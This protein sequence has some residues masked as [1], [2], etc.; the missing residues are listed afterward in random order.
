MNLLSKIQSPRDL[1]TLTLSDL[2]HL[3]K[4]IRH[5]IIDVMAINGGHLG[6]NMGIVELSLALHRTFDAPID[7]LIFDV[8]HQTYPHKLLTGRQKEFPTIRQY[9]GL[10]G[11]ANPEESE[12]DTFFAGHAGTALSLGLGTAKARDLSH[13]NFHVI[14]II[15]DATFTCGLTLEA[16]NNLPHDLKRFIVILNDNNM[17]ISD[18]VGAITKILEGNCKTHF[19]Q[20]GFEYVGLID[21]HNL[22][23]L[24]DILESVKHCDQPILLHAKTLKGK[25]LEVAEQNPIPWHGCSPFDK[26]TGEKLAKTSTKS[27]F[28]QI[29]GKHIEKMAE[30]D[31]AIVIVTPAMPLGSCISPLMKKFPER[32]IDV[33]IAEGHAVTYSGGIASDPSKKVVC[34][35]YSTFL[36]RGLDNLFQ[37]VC[38]QNAPVVFALDRAGI[39]TGDGITHHGIYDISF[40]NAMPNMVICQPRDGHL[41]KELLESAFDWK[42][43]TTLRYPNMAIDEPNL[44]IRQRPLGKGEILKKGSEVALVALGHMVNLAQEVSA[45][46]EEEGISTS[47]I[48]PIF[49]KPIDSDLFID[50]FMSHK[51]VVTLEEHAVNS[52]LGM[53]LNAFYLNNRL[54]GIRM[55]NFGIPDTFLHQGSHKEMLASIGLD[56]VS[57][58]AQI[59][60]DYAEENIDAYDHRTIS[61]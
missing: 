8:S 17:S 38:L 7:R 55:L 49:V 14:P 36:Q 3:A 48:D 31:P 61:S 37:D 32:C 54:S 44:P 24:L 1:K 23:E 41:L 60:K 20:F 4:E 2:E 11:F 12:Y 22:S 57:V 13:E 6:S 26:V 50:V 42:R 45:I 56:S 35:I 39:A 34:S 40:L 46:L 25:G 18:N 52:G 59:L 10:S 27:K 43:P 19:E 33:G 58:A 51:C 9:K 15:G 53:I 47:I 29:F 30:R 5:A 16:L 28:P 21:G